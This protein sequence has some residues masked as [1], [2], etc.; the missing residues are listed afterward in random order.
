MVNPQASI[1][2]GAISWQR[3]PHGVGYH[4][5]RHNFGELLARSPE[6]GPEPVPACPEWTVR[7]VLAHLVE[8]SAKVIERITGRTGPAVVP[9]SGEDVTDLLA[10]WRAIGPEVDRHLTATPQRSQIMVM[11]ALTHELDIRQPHME[12]TV[13]TL[14]AGVRVRPLPSA[15]AARSRTSHR[16]HDG[17]DS[18]AEAPDPRRWSGVDAGIAGL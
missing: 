12:R 1:A 11:D 10:R 8:I 15:A 16:C 5:I 14:T 13:A 2:T 7:D 3:A 9:A 4:H 17:D 18:G 6:I